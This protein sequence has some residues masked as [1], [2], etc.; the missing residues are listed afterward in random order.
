M[1]N[2]VIWIPADIDPVEPAVAKC[3]D[4]SRRRGYRLEGIVRGP[5]ESVR[6]MVTNR[7]VDVLIVADPAD[8]PSAPIPRIEVADG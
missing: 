1:D 5:W 7:A 2:A 4:Y 6:C 8:L 3:L